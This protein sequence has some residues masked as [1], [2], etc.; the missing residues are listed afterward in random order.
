M[1]TSNRYSPEVRE[2]AVRMVRD[3]ETAHASKTFWTTISSMRS[4]TTARR[5]QLV[6]GQVAVRW[7]LAPGLAIHPLLPVPEGAREDETAGV[8]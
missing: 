6:R 3:H 8:V 4:R 1:R 2:R 7:V 5:S